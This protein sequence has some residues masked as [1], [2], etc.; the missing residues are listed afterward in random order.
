MEMTSG[1]NA[2]E[3]EQKKQEAVTSLQQRL[4]EAEKKIKAANGKVDGCNIYKADQ[5]I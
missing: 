5:H 1:L 4:P 2:V 3:A